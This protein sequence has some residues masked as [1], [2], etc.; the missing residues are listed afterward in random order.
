MYACKSVKELSGIVLTDPGILGNI[1]VSFL[2]SIP[3]H[4]QFAGSAV[5]FD[6]DV[7]VPS[8]SNERHEMLIR[9]AASKIAW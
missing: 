1:V 8:T 5:F 6:K 4:N 9:P 7:N 3:Y 2:T